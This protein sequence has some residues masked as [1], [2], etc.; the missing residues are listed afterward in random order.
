MCMCVSAT[1]VESLEPVNKAIL[2][3]THTTQLLLDL[4]DIIF[5]W[6]CGANEQQLQKHLAV[7]NSCKPYMSK[8]WPGGKLRP[9]AHSLRHEIDN[10]G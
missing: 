10:T 1:F 3:M 6:T 9:V 7:C 2:V 5:L 4:L 8:V